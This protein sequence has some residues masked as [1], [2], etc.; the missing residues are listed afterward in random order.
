MVQI[1][2]RTIAV[3]VAAVFCLSSAAFAQEPARDAYG[4][5]AVLPTAGQ[6][7]VA[8]GGV[9]PAE[10][11]NQTA[12]VSS[13]SLPFTGMDVTLLGVGGLSLLALGFGV[14]RLSRPMA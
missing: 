7:K 5:G 12:K 10:G 4:G 2:R 11:A 3:A 9:L 13:D 6:N 14:R 8:G 1:Y